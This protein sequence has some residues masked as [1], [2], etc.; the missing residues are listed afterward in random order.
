VVAD[1]DAAVDAVARVVL[2]LDGEGALP[3]VRDEA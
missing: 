2:A 3:Y 1:V